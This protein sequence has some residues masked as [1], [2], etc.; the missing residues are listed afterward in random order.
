M[1]L[2]LIL[3]WLGK[4]ILNIY[5]ILLVIYLI[6]KNVELNIIFCYG[7]IFLNSVK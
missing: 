7:N 4:C 3:L 1:K 2:E 6:S 5:C